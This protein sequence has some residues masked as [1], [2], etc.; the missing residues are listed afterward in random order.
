M[1]TSQGKSNRCTTYTHPH[2]SQAKRYCYRPLFQ[3]LL[4]TLN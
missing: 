1:E 3:N 4:R 2:L